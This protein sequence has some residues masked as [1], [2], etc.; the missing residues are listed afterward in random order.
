MLNAEATRN[1][2]ICFLWLL[3]NADTS[4]LKTWWSDLPLTRL[5]RI[6]EVIYLEVSNF[7]Y[8]VSIFIVV[9]PLVFLLSHL[10]SFPGQAFFLPLMNKVF[11]KF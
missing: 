11:Y 2:L 4:V 8:K 3:K 5:S 9:D 6:L 10:I 7:E 1:L